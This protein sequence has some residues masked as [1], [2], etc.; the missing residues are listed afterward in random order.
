MTSRV[1]MVTTTAQV[2]INTH[3]YTTDSNAPAAE[4]DRNHETQVR[5][6]EQAM[7][8]LEDML[9]ESLPGATPQ[10]VGYYMANA[11]ITTSRYW[12]GGGERP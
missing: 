12:T 7:R 5:E 4:W 1:E 9:A 10:Q 6:R 11:L 3:T 8:D 2:T